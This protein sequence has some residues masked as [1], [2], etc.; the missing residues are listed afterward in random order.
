MKRAIIGIMLVLVTSTMVFAEASFDQIQ[1]LIKEQNYSAAVKGL[2]LIIQNHPKSAKAYYAMS[3]AQAGLGNQVKAKE[4]LDIATGIDPSL[5]FAS[6][7]N[8]ENLKE[9]LAPQ[10]KKIIAIESHTFRN[11]MIVL[12]LLGG[13]GYF[14]YRRKKKQLEEERTIEAKRIEDSYVEPVKPILKPRPPYR[15]NEDVVNK[16]YVPPTRSSVEA[17]EP[18]YRTHTPVQTSAPSH[19][20]VVNNN[21]GGGS[22]MLTGVLIGS[23]I[24]GGSHHDTHTERVVEREVVREPVREPEVSKSWDDTPSRSSSWSEPETASSSWEDKSSSSS[25]SSWSDSSSSSSSWDSGSSDSGS[26]SWD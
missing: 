7:S 10:T 17:S 21:S 19:T 11:S 9:A 24:S 8:V 4:A 2:E 3:Q 18:S 1:G 16:P 25:S 5:K 14:I 12:V 26:S 23:M 6:S 13:I 15:S 22:D 20:T